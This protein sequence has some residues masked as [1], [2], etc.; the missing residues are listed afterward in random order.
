MIRISDLTMAVSCVVLGCTVTR[1][2]EAS[3]DYPFKPVPFT[4][5]HL[6]DV[7][8]A[9]RIETNRVVTIP[10]AFQQCEQNGR[11]D[12][13][14]R[15]AA[16]LQGKSLTNTNPPP[17]PFDDTDPYKVLEGASYALAV[18]P[19]PKLDAYLDTL[20]AKIAPA[21]ESDGYLYT[22]RTINPKHPH[23]WSG[24]NRWLLDPKDS[25]ELYDAGHLFE[26]A[27]AHYQATGKRT[28]LNIALKEADLLCKT[29]GPEPT[30]LHIWPGHEIAEMGLVKLYRVTGEKRY[31]DLAR[32]SGQLPRRRRIPSI[33]H[34]TC[35]ANRSSRTRGSRRIFVQ[36]HG[37][38]RCADRGCQLS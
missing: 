32:C 25:H 29:F 22:A 37:R 33:S 17:Y 18:K 2:A 16:A 38:R 3:K 35:E 30:K 19:D 9:P 4:S 28:L 7:F 12:N 1:G 31:L 10:F 27:V 14:D 5:V 26:A 20:I 13:F 36:R 6:D 23:E 8:W 34:H 24:T 21:Q 11:M 15:A